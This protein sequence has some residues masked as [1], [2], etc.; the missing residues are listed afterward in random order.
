MLG[1]QHR[2]GGSTRSRA[3]QML[4]SHPAYIRVAGHSALVD[5]HLKEMEKRGQLP[6]RRKTIE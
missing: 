1:S 5:Q 2:T 3:G 4:R 6:I